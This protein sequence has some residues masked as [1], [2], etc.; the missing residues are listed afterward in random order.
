M[1]SQIIGKIK[2]VQQ[3][4]AVNAVAYPPSEGKNI[5]FLYGQRV[6]YYA[7]LERALVE[8]EKLLSDQDEKDNNL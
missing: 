2:Q 6:G 7:G 8:I 5:E 4:I 1:I 3:E